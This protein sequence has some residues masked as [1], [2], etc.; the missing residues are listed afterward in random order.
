MPPGFLARLVHCSLHLKPSLKRVLALK[1]A[2]TVV[3]PMANE[4]YHT[5]QGISHSVVPERSTNISLVYREYQKCGNAYQS[6]SQPSKRCTRDRGWNHQGN[7]PDTTRTRMDMCSIRP[8]TGMLTWY[9]QNR[10]KYH[11]VSAC[12]TSKRRV[13]IE[14]HASRSYR[15]RTCDTYH[16]RP[17]FRYAD[18]GTGP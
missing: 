16:R 4:S 17:P 11:N 1:A 6:V 10:R 15:E 9:H 3:T 12:I 13:S 2:L 14:Y 5:Y 18:T 8:E 7:V